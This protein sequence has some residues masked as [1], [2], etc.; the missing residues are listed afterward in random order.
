M[1]SLKG[2]YLDFPDITVN[3][4][5]LWVQAISGKK[6]DMA[7]N[8]RM[9]ILASLRQQSRVK[10]RTSDYV[11]EK[12]YF[13]YPFKTRKREKRRSYRFTH[14]FETRK[15]ST[16]TCLWRHFMS[17]GKDQCAFYNIFGC[18]FNISNLS[19]FTIY[20]NC[21]VYEYFSDYYFFVSFT[22]VNSLG[23]SKSGPV[24]V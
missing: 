8:I 22:W 5:G 12:K 7:A 19:L 14:P 23:K 2:S 1:C 3:K 16:T 10:E 21:V 24:T 13:F 20:S 6:E 17:V 15:K 11:A 4:C 18:I 9:E